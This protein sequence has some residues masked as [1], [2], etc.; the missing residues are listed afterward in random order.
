LLKMNQVGLKFT[1]HKE[2]GRIMIRV[3]ESG[4]DKVIR[5]IPEESFLDLVAKMEQ[6]VGILFDHHA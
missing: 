1:Q 2:S 4:T 6:M 3:V 5:E